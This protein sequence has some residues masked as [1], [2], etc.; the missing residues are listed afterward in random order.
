MPEN[1]QPGTGMPGTPLTLLSCLQFTR[2]QLEFLGAPWQ[3]QHILP[4]AQAVH[5]VAGNLQ[6]GL[7]A[8]QVLHLDPIG[9]GEQ[10]TNDLR[11]V[12]ETIGLLFS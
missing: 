6:G 2:G 12:G 10:P 8:R 5:L 7:T 1:T 9:E 11:R 3:D 4:N